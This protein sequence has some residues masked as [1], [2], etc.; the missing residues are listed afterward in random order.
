MKSRLNADVHSPL[1]AGQW[2]HGETLAARFWAIQTCEGRGPHH[3][4]QR[5][6]HHLKVGRNFTLVSHRPPHHRTY[7]G[8][9]DA[10]PHDHHHAHQ[11]ERCVREM[12]RCC[13]CSC[14]KISQEFSN[15]ETL[16]KY[17]PPPPSFPSP[18]PSSFSMENKQISDSVPKYK[19]NVYIFVF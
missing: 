17:T 2:V 14:S 9:G 7:S 1:S 8:H 13:L 6:S 5:G 18:C 4:V 11:L 16:I 15:E 19:E 12:E 10:R 3:P